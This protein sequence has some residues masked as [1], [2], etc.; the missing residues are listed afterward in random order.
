MP[1]RRRWRIKMTKL[2]RVEI[3]YVGYVMA[4]SKSIAETYEAR[5]KNDEKANVHITESDSLHVGDSWTLDDIPYD[6]EIS[7]GDYYEQIAYDPM[8]DPNQNKLFGE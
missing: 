5:I 4:E 7:I 8:E 3:N 1:L 6:G 2:F